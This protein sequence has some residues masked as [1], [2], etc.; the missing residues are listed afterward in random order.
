[1]SRIHAP[2]RLFAARPGR[3]RVAATNFNSNN[4]TRPQQAGD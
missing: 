3:E 4:N 2:H 1:M